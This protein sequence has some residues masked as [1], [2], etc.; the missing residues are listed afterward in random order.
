MELEQLRAPAFIQAI[1]AERSRSTLVSFLALKDEDEL[2]VAKH[3]P[4]E[5]MKMI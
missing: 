2:D 3:L 4:R 5:I 1:P